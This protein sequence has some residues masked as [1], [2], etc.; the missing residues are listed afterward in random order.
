M[1]VFPPRRGGEEFLGE[2]LHAMDY[3]KLD[4][5]AANE[6]LKGKKVAVVGYK[7]SA[8]DLAVECAAANQG[9]YLINLPPPP[10]NEIL[11]SNFLLLIR[12]R[13]AVKM[14]TKWESLTS[15]TFIT[16]GTNFP[17]FIY[18]Y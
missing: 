15:L 10:D 18:L 13:R 14:V 6:L 9:I 16:Q 4:E 8:I 1:P 7:K 11:M 3:A 5:D 2:V 12:L 17:S